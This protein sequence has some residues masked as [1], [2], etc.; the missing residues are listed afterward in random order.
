MASEAEASCES[1]P[2]FAII[3][4]FLEKFGELCGIGTIDF[5]ELQNML[6][7][8]LEVP[9]E[10]MNLHIKLLRKTKKNVTVERWERALVN[11]CHS[12]SSKDAWEIE[13]F[14]YK[15]TRLQV[16]LRALKELL[17]MQFD[18]NTKFK[19]E[20]NKMSA[21]SLRAQPLGRDKLG[22]AYW[23]QTDNNYQ[24]RIYKEDPDEETWHLI[25]KDR[26][27]LL[28]L[29]NELADG[30]SKLSSDSALNEDSNSLSEKPFLDTGQSDNSNETKSKDN[31]NSDGIKS[32]EKDVPNSE[33]KSEKDDCK[34]TEFRQETLHNEDVQANKAAVMTDKDEEFCDDVDEE[35]EEYEDEEEEEPGEAD[36][37]EEVKRPILRIKALSELMEKP[38]ESRK[39]NFLPDFPE[40]TIIKK[41]KLDSSQITITKV[42]KGPPMQKEIKVSP[43][44]ES[45]VMII[46]GSGSGADNKSCNIIVSQEIEEP[47]MYVSGSGS[48]NDCQ[49]G[50]EKKSAEQEVEINP[51]VGEEIEEPVMYIFGEGSGEHCLAGKETYEEIIVSEEIE[52]EVMYIYGEGSG[53]DSQTG[54]EKEQTTT[55]E[56]DKSKNSDACTLQTSKLNTSEAPHKVPIDSVNIDTIIDSKT[57]S[58][59]PDKSEKQKEENASPVKMQFFF[60]PGSLNI[61]PNPLLNTSASEDE[62]EK[63]DSNNGSVLEENKEKKRGKW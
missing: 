29:I 63:P 6:E 37:K 50:N 58:E 46:K 28:S 61:K 24:I 53:C 39:A 36:I 25:A 9:L 42:P 1:D 14:G 55:P 49:S 43:A 4:A 30:D 38:K 8:N 45:P 3:C 12:Y 31:D 54:N 40:L 21:G 41:P 57:E 35:E 59:I 13:R 19:N 5:I 2:N 52:E 10:L 48:G 44:I 62:T 15:K 32:E 23:F 18:Y 17:E 20:V 27:G 7:N 56:T 33:Q 11:M 47:V 16:K 26:E 22:R 60:G 34:N 51:I